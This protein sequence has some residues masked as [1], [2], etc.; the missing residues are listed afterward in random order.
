[1]TE[2][3]MMYQPLLISSIFSQSVINYPAAKVI[4]RAIEGGLVEHRYDELYQRTV[5]LARCLQ[6]RGVQ[7]GDHVAT[8]AWNTHRHLETYYA[9]SGIG[10]VVHTVNPRLFDE[11][12]VYIINHAEDS[13]L[14]VDLSFVPLLDRI[15]DQLQHVEHIIILTDQA[16]MPAGEGYWCYES[17][18]AEHDTELTFNWPSFDEQ[19]AACLCY[20]SGTTGNPKGVM[21]SH[22]STVLHALSS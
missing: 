10:A 14:L 1:M 8:L 19:Q 5:A 12:I 17:L 22:R 3:T 20:T 4:S 15:R 7:A 13:W 18:L 6:Q 11:Q 21:Y 2:S 16:H 9:V